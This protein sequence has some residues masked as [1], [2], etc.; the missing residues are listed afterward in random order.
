[1]ELA[2]QRHG[3]R[4]STG[5]PGIRAW[6]KGG[7]L[8][9]FGA[10]VPEGLGAATADSQHTLHWADPSLVS[11]LRP[12]ACPDMNILAAHLLVLV[13]FQWWQGS[14]IPPFTAC[15]GNCQYQKGS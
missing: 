6:R 2:L 5:G 15:P 12:R 9:D 1:M 3:E 4:V 8:G 7:V 11:V 13:V 14:E 10:G